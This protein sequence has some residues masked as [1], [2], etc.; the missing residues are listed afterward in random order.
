MKDELAPLPRHLQVFEDSKKALELAGLQCLTQQWM[1]ANHAY[2]FRCQRGHIFERQ[3][4]IFSYGGPKRCQACESIEHIQHLHELAAAEGVKCLDTDWRGAAEYYRFECSKGHVWSRAGTKA[5]ENMRCPIC[6]QRQHAVKLMLPDGLLRLQQIAQSRG[7]QCLST[8]YDGGYLLYEFRCKAQHHWQ[9]TGSDVL[10]GSWCLLCSH[11]EKSEHY[12]LPD[13]LKRL[14]D[15]AQQKGGQC[16]AGTYTG[17]KAKYEFV[18]ARGHRWQTTG[19]GIALGAWCVQCAYDKK[20]LSIDDA[21]EAA[22]RRGGQCLSEHYV[23]STCKLEWMCERGHVW[24]ATLNTIRRNHWCAQCAVIARI[25]KP[26][27]TALAK[28]MVGKRGK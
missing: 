25:H 15:L 20:R 14:H 16:L 23:S 18:C 1:G 22:S 19:A 13:G 4:T 10:R 6:M 2:Q 27:S 17:G 28:Y 21:R 8:S 7:G 12:R 3:G 11:Q 9:A 5:R 26:N 24:T